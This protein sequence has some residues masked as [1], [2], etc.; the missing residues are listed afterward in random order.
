MS[1]TGEI[2]ARMAD[3]PKRRSY[4]IE[5]VERGLSAMALCDGN[6]RLAARLLENQGYEY[7][8]ETLRSWAFKIHTDRY[9]QAKAQTLPEIR[10]KMAKDSEALALAYAL[11]EREALG[12]LLDK[13]EDPNLKPAELAAIVRN[14]AVSRGVSVDKASAVRGLPTT[15]EASLTAKELYA[16][17]NKA[18]PG[19]VIDA[20]AEEITD[21]SAD[22]AWP[23][24]P[25]A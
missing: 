7:P 24:L 13:L 17:L 11:G 18:L 1:G 2:L 12:R 15:V 23:A 9:E 3:T 16:Q 19:A 6:Y 8:A 21:P 20:E 5:E 14:L 22:P 25:A 10:E 4:T